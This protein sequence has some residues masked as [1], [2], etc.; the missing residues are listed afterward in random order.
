M[1]TFV[2]VNGMYVGS[3][4][5]R[6]TDSTIFGSSGARPCGMVRLFT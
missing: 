2:L 4:R 5:L 6:H 1:A 3:R